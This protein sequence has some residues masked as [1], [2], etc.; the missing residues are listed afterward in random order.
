MSG[1]SWDYLYSNVHE[2]ADRLI[3]EN[4]SEYR[5]A[6]GEHLKEVAVVLKA[7]EWVDSGDCSHPHDEKAIKAFFGEEADHL[8]M[9]VLIEEAKVVVEKL[10]RFV[11]ATENKQDSLAAMQARIYREQALGNDYD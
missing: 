9:G 3:S 1:G 4:T 2:A 8:A 10:Q 11:D 7:I 6:F 5:S